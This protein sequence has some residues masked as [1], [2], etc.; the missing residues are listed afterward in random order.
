[1]SIA[2]TLWFDWI[3]RQFIADHPDEFMIL[4][5]SG[6]NTRA[7]QGAPPASVDWIDTDLISW[8]LAKSTG[9][10]LSS[11]RR[12]GRSASRACRACYAQGW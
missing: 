4:I 3:V 10:A 11:K 6:L 12:N 8:R 5:G 9:R 2:R 1:M 7:N